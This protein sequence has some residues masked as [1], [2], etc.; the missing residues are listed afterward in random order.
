MNQRA[1]LLEDYLRAPDAVKEA[2]E[3]FPREMW[4]YRPEDKSWTIHEI[5]IHLADSD[6]VSSMRCRKIIAENGSELEPYNQNAWTREL[7]YHAQ[8]PDDALNVMAVIRKYNYKMLK[9]V[10]ELIWA[11]HN[12]FHM[13]LGALTLDDWL[14]IYARHPYLHIEQMERVCEAWKADR[15]ESD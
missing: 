7:D 3:R 5:I 2:L 15:K 11:T 4:Q 10:P 13:D 9:L 14:S 8:D 1:Q 12:A 6:V